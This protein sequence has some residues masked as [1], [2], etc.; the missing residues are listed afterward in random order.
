MGIAEVAGPPP[1]A[2][3]AALA[4]SGAGNGARAPA[5]CAAGAK[6]MTGGP[7]KGAPPVALLKVIRG[8]ADARP[9]TRQWLIRLSSAARVCM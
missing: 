7:P 2:P 5:A 4:R 3:P 1:G 6:G 8:R 9:R